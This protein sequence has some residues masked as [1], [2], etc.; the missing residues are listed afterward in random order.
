MGINTND[1]NYM[2]TM[3]RDPAVQANINNLLQDPAVIDQVVSRL[4]PRRT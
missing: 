2:Q 1:P 3:M 4:A